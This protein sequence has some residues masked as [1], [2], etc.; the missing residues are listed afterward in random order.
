MMVV[1]VQASSL[2]AVASF[3]TAAFPQSVR[4]GEIA[5][6]GAAPLPFVDVSE[7]RYILGAADPQADA[8]V[9]MAVLR[10]MPRERYEGDD[11]SGIVFALHGLSPST[12][13]RSLRLG[14]RVS[15]LADA[16]AS[17]IG[18]PDSWRID[19]DEVLR[20]ILSPLEEVKS[21]PVRMRGRVGPPGK[22]E[23]DDALVW[24]KKRLSRSSA[25][26]PGVGSR[27]FVRGEAGKG[28]SIL[29]TSTARDLVTSGAIPVPLFIP[30]RELAS[31]RGVSWEEILRTVGVSAANATRAA[32]A[33]CHGLLLPVLDGLDEVAGRYDPQLVRDLLEIIAKQLAG[34]QARVVL[35][36][37]TTEAAQLDS[38]FWTQLELELPESKS[39]AFSEYVI[40]TTRATIPSWPKTVVQLPNEFL[41]RLDIEDIKDEPANDANINAICEWTPE[42]FED[43]GKDRSLF[44][45]Q[46]LAGI[47]RSRQ[48][49]G[50]K[51]LMVAGSNQPP[52]RPS[53]QDVCMLAA[54]MAC[55]R[56]QGKIEDFARETYTAE[57][58]LRLLAALALHASVEP[59][60]RMRLP[61]PNVLAKDLFE[62]DPVNSNELFTAILRQNQKHALLY[63]RGTSL[64]AGDWR[65]DFLSAWIRSALLVWAWLHPS[66]LPGVADALRR[67]AV[68]RAQQARLAFSEIFPALTEGDDKA[69]VEE[70][71]RELVNQAAQGSID[72]ATNHWL[73]WVALPDEV[74]AAIPQPATVPTGADLTE[75]EFTGLDLDACFSGSLFLLNSAVVEDCSLSGPT[76][77]DVDLTG[78]HFRRCTF[79]NVTFEECD[80]PIH[81]ENCEFR[82][83]RIVNSRS[84]KETPLA[85]TECEFRDGVRIEQA[86]ST[87][88]NEQ[89][90]P[91]AV[92]E[93]CT[94]IVPVRELLVGDWTGLVPEQ[95]EGL[96]A[97]SSDAGLQ[98]WEVCLRS[99]LRPFF[100]MRA[101]GEGQIQARRYIRLSALGRGRFPPNTPPQAD[102]RAVLE[103]VG[104]NTGGRAE[105]L[106]AP[107]ASING[108]P[109]PAIKLRNE[110]LAFLRGGT[111][112]ADIEKMLTKLRRFLE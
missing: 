60:L 74:R 52:W 34:P 33:V 3:V 62:V 96:D 53:V 1:P 24:L 85:F 72:A 98:L 66:A 103:Q 20:R 41:H 45:V 11:L 105:H 57:R 47:A 14:V 111:R 107:W 7:T 83:T 49:A 94:S 21:D 68:A 25:G 18:L 48:L 81:F 100:P 89:V 23:V 36:G 17:I 42:I 84:R 28:K 112:S 109:P 46:G 16:V 64:A 55:V 54:G 59:S 93:E 39:E 108:A 88:S 8:D 79:E 86:K 70:L 35:S 92:F 65:P 76:L 106:Y 51:P 95:V 10:S 9:I 82:D 29:L 43:F 37:R 12:G 6:D 71:V 110:M 31:G 73:L 40:A 19:Q 30:L 5:R 75:V 97:E 102:L 26:H 63:S 32:L 67:E 77:R 90:R 58:Q 15:P 99:M 87:Y 104:F 91:V 44:F 50:N 13:V 2:E 4:R 38:D 27:V 69:A 56:E 61:N 78:V 80:G 22:E 101:G